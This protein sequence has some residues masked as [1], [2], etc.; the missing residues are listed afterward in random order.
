[1][2]SRQLSRTDF[3]V[4]LDDEINLIQKKMHKNDIDSS[5]FDYLVNPEAR[6][7]LLEK[8]RYKLSRESSK[9]D[10]ELKVV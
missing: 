5:F 8:L 10:N 6:S 9:K 3:D 1:V 2:S 7:S 4:R